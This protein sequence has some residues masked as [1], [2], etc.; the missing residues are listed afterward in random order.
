MLIGLTGGIGSGKSTV[1]NYLKERGF[2]IVDADLIAREVVLP[3]SPA[4]REIETTFGNEMILED[5]TLDRKRLGR[6]VFADKDRLDQLN[7]IMSRRI[8]DEIE[9]R[10]QESPTENTVLDAATLIESGYER[11]VD[12]L[13]IVDAEDEVRIRRVME[14]DGATRQEVL[15]RM[16]HQ[17][18]RAERLRRNCVIIDNSGTLEQTRE[19]TDRAILEAK[20]KEKNRK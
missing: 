1:S 9:R 5:G 2:T 12:V 15:D 7:R 16:N 13:W 10:I 18:S 3:G 6:L 4:L 14:R 20:K 11:R 8:R 19:N 17:M